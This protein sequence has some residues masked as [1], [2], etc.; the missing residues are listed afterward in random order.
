MPS[1][2]SVISTRPAWRGFH[3]YLAEDIN[4]ADNRSIHALATALLD[5]PLPGVTDIIPSYT[6]LY[7]EYDANIVQENV[8][9]GWCEAVQ[10]EITSSASGDVTARKTV[11]VHYDGEDLA[12]I[13][14]RVGLTVQQVIDHHTQPDYHVFALGFTPGFAFMGNVPEAIH[15]PRRSSPRVRIPAHSVAMTGG[16]TGVYPSA[17]PGGWNLLG[18]ALVAMYDPQ[19]KPPFWLEPGDRVRFEAREGKPPADVHPL[20]LLPDNPEMPV[21]E[22]VKPGLLDIVVDGGRTM[23]GR[24]G[25]CRG[26]ML[27]VV[28]GTL[29]NR[30]VGN[31][32][33]APMLE[34]NVV[35]GRYRALTPCVIGLAGTGM[36]AYKNEEVLD[37]PCSI[38]LQL[39]DELSFTPSYVGVR[40]YMAVAGGIDSKQFMGSSS[41][42]LN[43]NIGKPL[44]A[45]VVLGQQKQRDVHVASFPN[46]QAHQFGETVSLR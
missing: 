39:D 14:Q 32:P 34:L 36:L 43:G 30:L 29:A 2:K 25:L 6:T 46:F 11:P 42:D 7:L 20:D 45:G 18:R 13:S 5:K 15:T 35:G 3:L 16:Q 38:Q 41:V 12:E 33:F 8:V 17:S 4:E 10:T 24:Y 9:R 1:S 44:T 27:D 31:A 37:P 19:R 28:S 22:V 26:G 23:A 21:L 40:M